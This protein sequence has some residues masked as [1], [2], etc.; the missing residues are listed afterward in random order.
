M[1]L[2][3]VLIVDD[4]DK[5]RNALRRDLDALDFHLH[6]A[7]RATAGLE[8][9][10]DH[11]IDIVVCD[12]EMPGMSGLKF[13]RFVRQDYPDVI[14]IMLTGHATLETAITAI[15][16]DEIFRFLEKPWDDQDLKFVLLKACERIRK[17]ARLS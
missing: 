12:N 7:D 17:E 14:R 11:K 3:N 6:F 10:R 13:L 16:Q 5:V 4:D 1:A 2:A 8:I 9:L 15:N